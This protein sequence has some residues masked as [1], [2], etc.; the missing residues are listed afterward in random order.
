MRSKD[1]GKGEM[2]T[3]IEHGWKKKGGG[4]NRNNNENSNKKNN[5]KPETNLDKLAN[6]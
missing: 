1:H 6:M 5:I 2:L 3:T 4:N